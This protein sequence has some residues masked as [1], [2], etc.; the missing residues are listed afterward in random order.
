LVTQ[1]EKREKQ[2]KK[3]LKDLIERSS[4]VIQK[5]LLVLNGDFASK[6]KAR[7]TYLCRLN[8]HLI[9]DPIR[10]S[11]TGVRNMNKEKGS[12]GKTGKRLSLLPNLVNVPP[13]KEEGEF[14]K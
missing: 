13:Q 10:Y 11:K 12:K 5:E 6:R 3:T 2:D 7:V 8:T 4:F 1:P 9:E 14:E